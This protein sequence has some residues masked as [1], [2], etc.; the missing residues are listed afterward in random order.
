MR[1]SYFKWTPEA[2]TR[3]RELA[4]TLC[5]KDIAGQLGCTL[6]AVASEMHKLKISVRETD[7]RLAVR[8]YM[9]R[10]NVSRYL[11]EKVGVDRL[12]RMSEEARELFLHSRL[13]RHS[14]AHSKALQAVRQ[15]SE[16]ERTERVERMMQLAE[17]CA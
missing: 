14:A 4:G 9:D 17:R 16:T 11:V 2:V 1:E 15:L 5:R 7:R 6:S 12:D 13:G 8:R 3:L 10:Y